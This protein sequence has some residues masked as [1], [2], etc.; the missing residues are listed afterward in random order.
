M[1]TL[2]E[3]YRIAE[4]YERIGSENPMVGMASSWESVTLLR[5]SVSKEGDDLTIGSLLRYWL[6]KRETTRTSPSGNGAFKLNSSDMPPHAAEKF[7]EYG[8]GV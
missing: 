7:E 5:D 8:V 4:K 3:I 1:R 6:T 2:S